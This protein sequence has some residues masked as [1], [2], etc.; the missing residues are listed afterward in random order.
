MVFTSLLL[1]S[2][3]PHPPNKRKNGSNVWSHKYCVS[4]CPFFPP[5]METI[6]EQSPNFH[7][8]V[9]G[10]Q[11]TIKKKISPKDFFSCKMALCIRDQFSDK[12]LCSIEYLVIFSKSKYLPQE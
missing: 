1:T 10:L 8:I 11:W 6:S 2:A 4:L 3:A 5:S 7:K 9:K 12:I